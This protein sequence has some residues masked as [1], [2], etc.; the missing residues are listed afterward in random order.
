MA[1]ILVVRSGALGDT[2]LTLPLLES[3]CRFRPDCRVLFVGSRAYKS[4][5]PP[6]ISFQA[7]DSPEWLWLFSETIS[8]PPGTT[9]AFKE[10]YVILNQPGTVIGNLQKSG[11]KT[12]RHTS[13]KPQAG[14]HLV[15]SMHL[16]LGMPIPARAPALSHLSPT[17][18]KDLIW[19]H[20]GSGSP[21]KCLPL[22]VMASLAETLKACTGW[23]LAVTAGREDAFLT[24]HPAWERLTAAPGTCLYLNRPLAE[25]CEE[26]GAARLFVGNDSGISHMAAGLGVPSIVFFVSTEPA[27]WAPWVPEIQI[28]VV[29]VR[30][31]SRDPEGLGRDILGTVDIISFSKT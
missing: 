3:I 7:L 4:L 2:I 13:S 21:G 22:D 15:E 25:I 28:K 5:V 30:T 23:D 9:D 12:I 29:D 11:V 6:D 14:R 17:R 1:R 18:T 24:G 31:A 10:A 19:L 27:Q 20:P 16:G 8:P 26:L